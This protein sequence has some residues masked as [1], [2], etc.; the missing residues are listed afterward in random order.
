MYHV[1]MGLLT[2][3]Q[4]VNIVKASSVGYNFSIDLLQQIFFHRSLI[5]ILD[6]IE[7]II[8]F[9]H[10]RLDYHPTVRLSWLLP[11]YLG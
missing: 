9:V 6:L 4:A 7:A 10:L 2:Y 11:L 3:M 8:V 5:V 1:S